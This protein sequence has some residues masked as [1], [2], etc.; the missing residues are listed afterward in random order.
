MSFLTFDPD[1]H[2]IERLWLVQCKYLV[3]TMKIPS[4]CLFLIDSHKPNNIFA[5]LIFDPKSRH[6]KIIAV[7]IFYPL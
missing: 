2:D 4:F 3:P 1:S 5:Y 6:M 7:N